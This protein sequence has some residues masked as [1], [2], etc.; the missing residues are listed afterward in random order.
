MG[1]GETSPTMVSWHRRLAEVSTGPA[2]LLDTSYGF[3]ENASEI[4]ERARA[5]FAD[6]VGHPIEVASFGDHAG[7][8]DSELALELVRT[9]G[10]LFAGPGSPTYTLRQWTGTAMPGAIADRLSA[11][12]TVCLASAAALTLGAHSV[13]VYEIYK[14]GEAPHWLEG[15]DL[16]AGVGLPGAAVIPHFDNSEGGGHDTRFCY[17]GERRLR[18]MELLADDAVSILGIDEHSIAVLDL[19]AGTITAGGRGAVW[20]RRGGHVVHQLAGDS[21]LLTEFFATEKTTAFAAPAAIMEGKTAG[22]AIS[23]LI[24]QVE[25]S[26]AAFG[27]AIAEDDLQ[28]AAAVTLDLETEIAGWGADTLQSNEL[29][30]ARAALRSMITRLG[31]AGAVV[32]NERARAASSAEAATRG[33]LEL[34]EEARRRSD[35][36]ASDRLRDTLA[37]AGVEVRDTAEG[38]VWEPANGSSLG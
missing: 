28:R 15:L 11:G 10:Y 21:A 3:Q 2:V 17:L 22:T 7:A 14:S 25:E 38:Q 32:A 9:A 23:P 31:A 19:A 4:S 13:P 18:Q 33:L 24:S 27:A 35:Y 20:L 26:K 16:M 37:A 34:R 8:A 12:A 30:L 36:E 6:N 29:D 5:Y 1:S